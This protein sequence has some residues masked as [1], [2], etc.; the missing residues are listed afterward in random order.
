LRFSVSDTGIGISPAGQARLFQSFSQADG[1]TTRRYGGTGLG[2]AIS[3]QLVE[4]MGGTIACESREG[5]GSTFTFT[6][7]V[8]PGEASAPGPPG[9]AL[10]RLRVLIVD[11]HEA[12]RLALR[13]PLDGWGMTVG[14]AA[15]KGEALAELREAARGGHAYDVAIVALQLPHGEGGSLARA[16]RTDPALAST[17]LVLLSALGRPERVAPDVPGA[18][19]HLT[20]PVRRSQLLDVL[21][22]IVGEERAALAPAASRPAPASLAGRVLVVEDNDVNREVAVRF[23]EKLGYRSDVAVD[24]REAVAACGRVVYDA[25]LMDCQM[26]EMDG[27]EATALIRNADGDS[28]R[29]P[30]IAMTASALEGDRDRCLAAGMDDYLSK[31]VT[32]EALDGVLGRW[33]RRGAGPVT[34]PEDGGWPSAS[35]TAAPAASED[36]LVGYLRS[37]VEQTSP[38]IVRELL[39]GFLRTAPRHLAALADAGGRGD[40]TGLQR[41]AH[42]LRGMSGQVGV[43]RVS[44]LAGRIEGLVREGTTTDL[45]GL[46]DALR[47]EFDRARAVLERE[48]RRLAEAERT[49]P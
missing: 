27:F 49:G 42:A 30:I 35:P 7:R 46:L 16:M 23:L 41:A 24:G 43:R 32:P 45:G 34:T 47:A 22:K 6:V 48:V 21:M 40:A 28:R 15:G 31:P 5:E 10:R 19:G 25:V 11:G 4:L 8:R 38:G 1:S 9:E 20:K 2:L 36:G 12:S 33:V 44:E 14:A 18:A 26:P 29:V 17:Q 3:K 39:D 13:E 37:F